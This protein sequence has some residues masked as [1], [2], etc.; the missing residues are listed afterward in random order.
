MP[1]GSTVNLIGAS[2]VRG[3]IKG[4]ADDT[5]TSILNFDLTI[6]GNVAAAQTA[7]EAAIAQYDAAYVA[8]PAD[9]QRCR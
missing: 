5:S 7:L 8:A 6:R 2:P 4:G 1:T 3:L 9:G